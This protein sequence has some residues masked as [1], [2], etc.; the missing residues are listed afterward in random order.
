MVIVRTGILLPGT[1]PPV[2]GDNF[3][4]LSDGII[5]PSLVGKVVVGDDKRVV[6]G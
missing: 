3:F 5:F 6:G 1:H 4:G 2:K